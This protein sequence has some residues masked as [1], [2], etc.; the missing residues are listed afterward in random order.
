MSLKNKNKVFPQHSAIGPH[1]D[2]GD[3]VFVKL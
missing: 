3:V 2:C 1:L